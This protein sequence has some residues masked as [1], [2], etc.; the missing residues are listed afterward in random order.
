MDV[1]SETFIDLK[2][3][4]KTPSWKVRLEGE[5]HV[6]SVKCL[7]CKCMVAWV[8]IPGTHTKNSM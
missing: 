4:R 1:Y 3:Y 6:Q 5:K 8:Q 7:V 2:V